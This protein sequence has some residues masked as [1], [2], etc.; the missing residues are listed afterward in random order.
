MFAVLV[1]GY[2]MGSPTKVFV[3]NWKTIVDILSVV[4]FFVALRW[5]SSHPDYRVLGV[6]RILRIGQL[7]PLIGQPS[8]NK[9]VDLFWRSLLES[10]VPLRSPYAL[11]SCV[12][13]IL[14]ICGS[15]AFEARCP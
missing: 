11:M 4:P 6:I 10:V 14:F 8:L 15:M 5:P 3:K 13:I 12:G 2:L 7:A 9:A 1:I